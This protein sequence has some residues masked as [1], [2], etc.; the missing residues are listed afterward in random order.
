MNCNI[1]IFYRLSDVSLDVAENRVTGLDRAFAVEQCNCPPGYRGLSCEVSISLFVRTNK[2][3]IYQA[4]VIC[5]V[6]FHE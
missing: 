1:N 4:N 2:G 5:L 6:N 3:T